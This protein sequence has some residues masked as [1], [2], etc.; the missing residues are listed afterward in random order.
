MTSFLD[1]NYSFVFQRI[2]SVFIPF[3][4]P[5]CLLSKVLLSQLDKVKRS[6]A[7]RGKTRDGCDAA[8]SAVASFHFLATKRF[9]GSTRTQKQSCRAFKEPSND[10]YLV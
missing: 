6:M 1:L 9:T 7:K 4:S 3:D 2:S 10:M 5:F 8:M